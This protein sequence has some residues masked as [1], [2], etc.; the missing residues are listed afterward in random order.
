M[1]DGKENLFELE[2]ANQVLAHIQVL[3]R[4]VRFD[5]FCK[6]RHI[7]CA[8]SIVLQSQFLEA[9]VLNEKIDD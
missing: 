6:T 7:A 2:I 9:L 5:R 4:L 1:R 8:K 3:Q